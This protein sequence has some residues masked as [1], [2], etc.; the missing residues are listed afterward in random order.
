MQVQLEKRREESFGLVLPVEMPFEDMYRC[1]DN[2][3]V[4]PEAKYYAGSLYFK[5]GAQ[6][7]IH[8]AP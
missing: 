7:F 2:P 3:A 8:H 4:R 5:L 1:F 6:K